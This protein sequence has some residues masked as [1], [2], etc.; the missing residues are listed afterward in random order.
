MWGY[1]HHFRC[2]LELALDQSLTSI[3]LSVAPLA[4]LI[5]FE[6]A[7]GGHPIC[8]EPEN[9]GVEQ[10]VFANCTAEGDS[11]YERHED[12]RVVMTDGRLHDRF[13]RDLRDKC[14]AGAIAYALNSDDRH[15]LRRWFAGPSASVGRYRVYPT[16]GVLRNRWDALPSLTRR[17]RDHHTEMFLSLQE[18]VVRETLLSA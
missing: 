9:I 5:G 16:I 14:R 11:A 1:Q 3:G 2:H 7:S 15:S 12:R 8:V 4:L 6:E 10:E 13:H 18:A 17:D